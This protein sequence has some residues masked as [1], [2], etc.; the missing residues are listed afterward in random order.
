MPKTYDRTFQL[1]HYPLPKLVVEC[2]KCGR[3]GRFVVAQLIE[4]LGETYPVYQANDRL[5]QDWECKKPDAIPADALHP[6]ATYCLPHLPE[7]QERVSQ[8]FLDVKH[9]RSP[10][11]LYA[12]PEAKVPPA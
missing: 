3:Q 1:R 9:G 10:E 2:I 5:A 6:R 11:A 7:W 8:F 4:K 12:E